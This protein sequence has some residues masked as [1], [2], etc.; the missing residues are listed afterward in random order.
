MP[1]RKSPKKTAKKIASRVRRRFPRPKKIVVEVPAEKA[2]I[3]TKRVKEALGGVQKRTAILLGELLLKGAY[4]QI[5]ENDRGG[6]IHMYIE[7]LVAEDNPEPEGSVNQDALAA[8]EEDN[9]NA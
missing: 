3:L 4:Y 5:A 1:A 2:D 8:Q 7:E 6:D 9:W